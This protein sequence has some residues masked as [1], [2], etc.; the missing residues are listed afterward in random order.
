[1]SA[2]YKPGMLLHLNFHG[3]GKPPQTAA[4]GEEHYW[5]D[6]GLFAAALDYIQ[7]RNHVNITI[8]DSNESDY[9]VALPLLSERKLKATFFVVAQRIDQRGFLSGGQIRALIAEGMSIGNHGMRHSRWKGMSRIQLEEEL[10]TARDVIQEITNTPITEAACPFGSYD[11]R[12]LRMLREQGYEH[13]YTSDTGAAAAAAW[14][15]PRNTI[16]RSHRLQDIMSL[17][18]A[19]PAGG[20]QSLR[21]LKIFVKSWL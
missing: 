1:M 10:V 14:L 15:Q 16:N 7:G 12:A 8:D 3:L 18:D 6:P 2:A 4:A 21:D 19:P 13:A 20:S 5:I 17:V 11:R 9:E